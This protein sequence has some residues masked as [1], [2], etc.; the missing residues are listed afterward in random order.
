LSGNRDVQEITLANTGR[1]NK[2]APEERTREV[3]VRIP[4]AKMAITGLLAIQT[5]ACTMMS[6]CESIA[7]L[8][9]KYQCRDQVAIDK[10]TAVEAL[11]AI[12]ITGAKY[13]YSRSV[14]PDPKIDALVQLFAGN[15]ASAVQEYGKYLLERADNDRAAALD[16]L[17]E[18]QR[19]D[20]AVLRQLLADFRAEAEDGLT[21]VRDVEQTQY[22]QRRL[23]TQQADTL[24]VIKRRIE[25]LDDEAPL[26]E[27]A[28]DIYPSAAD[29][30]AGPMRTTSAVSKRLASIALLSRQAKLEVQSQRATLGAIRSQLARHGLI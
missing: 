23:L 30:V 27:R 24:R 8:R 14:R 10:D 28:L 19:K 2:I 3:M 5:S 6:E 22:Q 12:L 4:Y 11:G 9:A 29:F 7:D 21:I 16:S 26:Y 18:A 15:N 17:L 20:V 25:Q 13:G 1:T